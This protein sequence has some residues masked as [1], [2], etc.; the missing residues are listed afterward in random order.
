MVKEKVRGEMLRA[1]L[2][3]SDIYNTGKKWKARLWQRGEVV[4]NM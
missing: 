3:S 4:I 2:E 1:G